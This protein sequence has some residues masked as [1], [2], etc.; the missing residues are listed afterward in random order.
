M[1]DQVLTVD[2]SVPDQ[3]LTV[4]TS[5]DAEENL[6]DVQSDFRTEIYEKAAELSY[7]SV[8][9][10]E[11]V[12]DGFTSGGYNI[13]KG[14]VAGPILLATAPFACAYEEASIAEVSTEHV[15]NV[16]ISFLYLVFVYNSIRN[17]LRCAVILVSYCMQT[18]FRR[19]RVQLVME[20]WAFST[21][22]FEGYSEDLPL[23]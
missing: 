3:A 15:T 12:V 17:V 21:D 2:T 14:L 4:D 13:L 19:T 11:N 20:F 10:P 8:D 18:T 23:C 16:V 5:V 7:F 9:Q 22:W 6:D 1:P